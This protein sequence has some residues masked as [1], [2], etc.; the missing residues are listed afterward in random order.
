L[1]ASDDGLAKRLIT[2]ALYLVVTLCAIL[3]WGSITAGPAYMQIRVIIAIIA[4][5]TFYLLFAG[6]LKHVFGKLSGRDIQ[7][8][9]QIAAD[10]QQTALPPAHNIPV[11]SLGSQRVNTAE[12]LQPPSVTEQTTTLLDKDKR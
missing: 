10:H 12:M 5:V 1:N 4:A 6:D 11:A 9:K 8:N 2:I 7:R 3:G